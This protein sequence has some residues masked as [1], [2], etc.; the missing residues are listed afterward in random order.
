MLNTRRRVGFGS[1][2]DSHVQHCK[3]R[4]ALLR[5]S[6]TAAAAQTVDSC[7]FSTGKS[8]SDSANPGSLSR[9]PSGTFTQLRIFVT[10]DI[11]QAR[12]RPLGILST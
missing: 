5:P 8:A 10:V 2:V 12:L 6:M 9:D 7:H 1:L 4:R 11:L 3:A